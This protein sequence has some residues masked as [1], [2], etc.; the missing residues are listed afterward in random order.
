MECFT[1]YVYAPN[2]FWAHRVAQELLALLDSPLNKAGKLQVRQIDYAE[3][4]RDA[5]LET[6]SLLPFTNSTS[7]LL[8]VFPACP[9]F[10]WV[11]FTLTDV[12]LRLLA[13]SVPY[14]TVR[15]CTAGMVAQKWNDRGRT[16]LSRFCFSN[17]QVKI[18]INRR[19][20]V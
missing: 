16:Y 3:F 4:P 13:L 12:V 11:P 9:Y 2:L 20:F 5:F 1:S 19:V 14:G 7:C 15:Y 17:P 10:K 6:T 18:L 8:H